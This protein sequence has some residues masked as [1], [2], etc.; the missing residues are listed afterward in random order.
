MATDQGAHC[1]SLHRLH[2]DVC[3]VK[4]WAKAGNAVRRNTLAFLY[5]DDVTTLEVFTEQIHGIKTGFPAASIPTCTINSVQ[6]FMQGLSAEL[7]LE[8][9]LKVLL[10]NTEGKPNTVPE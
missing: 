10:L 4:L 3:G 6:G 9:G 1:V 2:Q 5:T 7:G 8:G